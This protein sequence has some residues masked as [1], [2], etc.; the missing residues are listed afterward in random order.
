MDDTRTHSTTIE[1]MFD[2]GGRDE[3][4]SAFVERIAAMETVPTGIS[5]LDSRLGG[6]L[7]RSGL[8]LLV[9]CAPTGQHEFV[10]TAALEAARAGIGV[11][12]LRRQAAT[13]ERHFVA[14]ISDLRFDRIPDD[15]GRSA[16]AWNELCK[17]PIDFPYDAWL[18]LDQIDQAIR[19]E[20][21]GPTVV[22]IDSLESVGIPGVDHP[23][24]ADRA[25]IV[26]DIADM[27]R[28]RE[29]CVILLARVPLAAPTA[30]RHTPS[31]SDLAIPK[32]YLRA[33]DTVVA[34]HHQAAFDHH[35]DLT[36]EIDVA[37]VKH[38]LAIDS[39]RRNLRL[40]LDESRARLR[41]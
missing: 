15:E 3:S 18:A 36:T 13:L 8:T 29:V 9:S 39:D 21:P 4:P 23:S 2:S 19:R 16:T 10:V 27:A 11:H 41:G 33:A 30:H 40:D 31:I 37:I 34:L 26:F 12:I 32:L 25:E 6:G 22:V 14:N 17:L 24:R 28:E 5:E 20:S 7:P 38:P 35:S 1:R